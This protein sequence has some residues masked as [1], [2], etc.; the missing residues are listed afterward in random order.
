M[1]IPDFVCV[2][3]SGKLP[4]GASGVTTSFFL[5]MYILHSFGEFYGL[6]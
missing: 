5:K 4:E 3:N 2:E 1:N 6:V